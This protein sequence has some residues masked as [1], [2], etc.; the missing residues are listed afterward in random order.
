MRTILFAA[1]CLSAVAAGAGQQMYRWTGADGRV[2]YT[3]K[4]PPADAKAVE[5]KKLGDRAG[6][7]PLPYALL[8]ATK[9]FPVTLF[10]TDCGDACDAARKLLERRGIPHAE[11]NA[12]DEPVQA[13]L[14]KLTGVDEIDVPLLVVGKT[15]VRGWEEAQ[16]N[17]ALDAANYPK[18]SQLPKSRA[19]KPAAKPKAD[20]AKPAAPAPA[21][22][23]KP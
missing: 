23:P 10:T 21:A 22:T 1:L 7:G 20:D 11:K 12:R 4:A 16:W 3:D 13:E 18:T 8:Q 19:P 9:A 5:R 17:A 14:K 6:T 15:I 2:Y